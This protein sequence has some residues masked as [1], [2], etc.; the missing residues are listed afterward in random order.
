MRCQK[1]Y[2]VMNNDRMI[3]LRD[4]RLAAPVAFH[5][6]PEPEYMG[7]S[8]ILLSEDDGKSFH[9]CH[10]KLTLPSLQARDRGMQEPGIY[11]HEDGTLRI[12]ARTGNGSQYESFSR[13]GLESCTPPAPSLFTSPCSPMELAKDPVSG[14]I[15]AVYNP[16]P[17]C[18]RSSA[19]YGNA[20]MGGRTPLVIRKSKDDGKTWDDF[21]IV[22]SDPERGYCYEAMFFTEDRHML[23]AYCRG[24]A[25]DGSCLARLGIAKLPMDE[26]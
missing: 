5:G 16:V 22:E 10:I 9:G 23:L 25:E 4:G 13:D 24:N 20:S 17:S 26:I 19:Q 18:Y 7:I 2:Y 14:W 1:N 12:W 8:T 3:R 21:K 15:Y 11:E 6:F